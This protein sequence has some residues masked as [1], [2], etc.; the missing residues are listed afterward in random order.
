MKFVLLGDSTMADQPGKFAP[1]KGWGQ[2]LAN[3][4]VKHNLFNIDEVEVINF[5]MSS[6]STKFFGNDGLLDEVLAQVNKNDYVIIQFGQNDQE[7][8]EDSTLNKFYFRIKG[9]LKRVTEKGAKTILCTPVERLNFIDG[10]QIKTLAEYQVILKKLAIET[11]TPIIDLN[12]YTNFLYISLGEQSARRLF[13]SYDQGAS[14]NS[15]VNM[16]TDNHLSSQ[17]AN[18]I[19]RYVV[20]RLA[21]FLS[22]RELFDQYYYGA[23]MYPE[24]CSEET[25]TEDITRMKELKMN[26]ARIGEFIWSSLEPQEGVYDFS[27]LEKSLDLYQENDIAVCL[28]IPTPTPPRWMTY[29][30]A[31]RLVVNKD[32][33]H[34]VHGSRQHIC[35]NNNYFRNKAYQLTQKIAALAKRYSN[36]IAIQLDN[37][38]KCHVDKCYCSSC[39]SKWVKWL[40][41]EYLE[42]GTL[43]AAW[44]TKIWSEEYQSFEEVV[45]PF[46]TPFIHNSALQNAFA[47]FTAES[48]NEFAHGLCHHIRIETDIP[49]THNTALGFNLINEEL[50]SELDIVGFDTYAPAE[51]YTSYLL[52]LDLWRNVKSTNS[53][54]MLLETSTSHV[55][56][57]ENYAEEHP[58]G[59]LQ[60]EAFVGFA[61]GLKTFS[62]WHFR[63]HNYG[64]EQTHSSV[65]TAWGTPG[66]GYQ[67][68]ALNGKLIEK[69]KPF[70]Q[71]SVYKSSTIAMIYS[72]RSKHFYN[73]ETG[74]IYDYRSLVTEY[75]GSLIKAGI[76]LEVIQENSDFTHYN[77]LFVPFIRAVDD[78]L[79]SKLSTFVKNGGKLILGSMTGDRTTELTWPKN[80]GLDKIGEWLNYTDVTQYKTSSHNRLATIKG[81]DEEF[82]GLITTFTVDDTWTVFGRNEFGEAIAAKKCIGSGSIIYFGGLPQNLAESESWNNLLSTEIKPLGNT[83]SFIDVESGIIHYRR[84]TLDSVQLYVA[85][86]TGKKKYFNS[87]MDSID[88][89]TGTMISK[90]KCS[91]EQY[92]YVILKFNKI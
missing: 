15:L 13:T 63:G 72:D 24:M 5:A 82:D 42:V 36:V 65:L 83:N 25:L 2:M 3:Q 66:R 31:E 59:Y 85:N 27:T 39:Q 87:L 19:A 48:L 32:G 1:A 47:R 43:N 80:N 21:D 84:D 6:T 4:L 54:M 90:G 56:H 12:E 10:E 58:K 50:F 45:M 40:E 49:I 69:M 86:M 70:L 22:N 64:V 34:M 53:E 73:I 91:L 62:Y 81:Y 67:E 75:H 74:G 7:S 17:G 20:I 92:E 16:P 52:N 60:I 71:E 51:L 44:G 37:E 26:F 29:S 55:G 8:T 57:I 30:H 35:T 88:L 14:N 76:P 78:N 18:E 33:T 9:L 77:V 23:C 41:E 46:S 61:A 68:V 11:N 79:L 28:C 38:F 89:L